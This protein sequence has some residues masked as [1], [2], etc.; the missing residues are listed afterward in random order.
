MLRHELLKAI[1]Y[2]TGNITKSILSMNAKLLCDLW[3]STEALNT[4]ANASLYSKLNI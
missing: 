4:H 1:F 2:T 3:A